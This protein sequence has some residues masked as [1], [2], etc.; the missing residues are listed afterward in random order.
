MIKEDKSKDNFKNRMNEVIKLIEEKLLPK[1]PS[2]LASIVKKEIN[3]LREL[4]MEAR[5]PRFVIVGRRGSGKS[6][7]INAI[8]GKK[9]AEVGSVKAMQGAGKWH[10]YKDKKG[11]I[12]IL[13]TR[14]LGEGA[15]PDMEAKRETPEEEI[16]DSIIDRCPDALLFLCKAKEVSARIDEDI[17]SL[18]ELKSYIREKHNYNPP[19]IAIITQI[20]ELDPPDITNPPYEDE[21]KKN[22]IA[23]AKTILSQKIENKFDDVIE[24]IPISAYMRFNGDE[25]ICDRRWN[26]SKLVEY[27]IEHM[28]N[29]AKIEL[30]KIAQ[31]KSIQKKVAR[32]LVGSTATIAG[33]IGAEPIPL[34]DLPFITGIQIG[35]IIGIGYISG[36]EMDKK[37]A[38][39]FMASMGLNVGLAFGFRELAR[40]LV[41]LIPIPGV[42]NAISG[43]IAA[44]ATWGIGEAAIAYFIDKKSKEET[45]QIYEKESKEKPGEAEYS[46]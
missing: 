19:I 11:T 6:S 7:L 2:K 15:K 4:I 3:K 26:I 42:G 30:A 43:A 1:L 23:F 41:K 17:K 38:A 32:I 45:K 29:S 39:E 8:F 37:T 24:V 22:N 18:S 33:A 21:E 10:D 27:L 16:K 20:D 5:A 28:P 25:I 36:K 44:G 12:S 31:V 46:G 9:V 34:A 14:G 35:M 40:A 13:D